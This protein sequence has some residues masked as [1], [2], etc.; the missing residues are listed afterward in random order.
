MLALIEARLEGRVLKEHSEY[1]IN[2]RSM[3]LMSVPEL[4]K[5]RSE[6]LVEVRREEAAKSG[7]RRKIYGSL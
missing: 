2:G 6:Y 1:S 3:K 4:M 5:A 7:C